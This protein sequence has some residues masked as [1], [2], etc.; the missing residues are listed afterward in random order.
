MT[1]DILR[2]YFDLTITSLEMIIDYITD[3][4]LNGHRCGAMLVVVFLQIGLKDNDI[5]KN[6]KH[7]FFPTTVLSM[8]TILDVVS[9]NLLSET[10]TKFI[11]N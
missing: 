5:E 11:E 3:V 1:G 4:C 2:I 9:L 6:G 10:F 7:V 8:N